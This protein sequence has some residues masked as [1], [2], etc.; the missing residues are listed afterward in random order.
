MIIICDASPLITL[1]TCNALPLLDSLFG[2]VY[3]SKQVFEEITKTG[4]PFSQ[5]LAE[6]LDNN[7]IQIPILAEFA[8]LPLDVGELSAF[9]LYK[10]LDADYLLIDEKLGRKFAKSLGFTVTGSLGI[11]LLAK[12]KGLIPVIRPYVDKLTQSPIY[13]S[14]QLIDTTLMLANES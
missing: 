2:H 6:Y 1:A 12:Q 8:D 5:E 4:K 11:L 3:V 7:F 9:S 10:K 13:L 14:Q